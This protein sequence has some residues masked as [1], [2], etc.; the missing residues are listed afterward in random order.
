MKPIYWIPL[1]ALVGGI[2]GYAVFRTTGWLG[3]TTGVVVG[4]L[5]GALLYRRGSNGHG[6]L[7]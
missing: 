6:P 3:A 5:I 4:A 2:I 1:L 7:G